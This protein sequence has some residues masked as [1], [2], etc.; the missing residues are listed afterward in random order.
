MIAHIWLS[1]VLFSSMIIHV[2]V[3]HAAEKGAAGKPGDRDR[4]VECHEGL[5]ESLKKPVEEWRASVHAATGQKCFLCHRGNPDANNKLAA[6]SKKDNF[7]GRPGK[8]AVPELCGNE[9]C[10]SIALTQFRK[11]PHYL[12]VAKVGQPHCGTCHG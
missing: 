11:S 6:H 10:H 4:C 5:D 9:G 1:F 8:N 7:I 2:S 12:T 3:L